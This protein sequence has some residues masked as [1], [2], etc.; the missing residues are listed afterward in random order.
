MEIISNRFLSIGE[1][2]VELSPASENQLSMGFAGDTFNTAWYISKSLPKSWD[3]DYLTAVGSDEISK[4]MVQ[5]INHAGIATRNIAKFCD[6]TVGL[7][8]I[9]TK[10]GERSFTYWR[11]NSAARKFASNIQHLNRGMNGAGIVFFSGISIA[12][13]IPEDRQNL[14]EAL[15]NA[16]SNGSKIVFDPNLRPALWADNSKM[17]EEISHFAKCAD[18]LL[19][20]FDDEALFFDDKNPEAT[21]VRYI[22]SGA[23]LVVVKN[24]AQSILAGSSAGTVEFKP[25]EIE[26]PVDTTAAG[27]AFNAGF[28]SA[29]FNGQ[30]IKSAIEIGASLSAKVIGKRG[31]LVDI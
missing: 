24:G 25:A 21:L 7:Y 17:C 16:R 23:E 9:H 13:L 15:T 5:F 10:N 8:M 20:S 19:P 12:I 28:L 26:N 4:D 1:C 11:E 31:A 3:V 2:M 6:R 29:Y 18:I 14:Y 30:D 22:S 27:D